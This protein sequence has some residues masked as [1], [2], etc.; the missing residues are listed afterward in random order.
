M[1]KGLFWT[2]GLLQTLSLWAI[3]FLIFRGLNQLGEGNVIGLD[4]QL[5]LS[6]VFPIFLLLVEYL[7]FN[8]G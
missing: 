5:V 1:K 7:I 8:K 2:F 4:A 3:I 6:I